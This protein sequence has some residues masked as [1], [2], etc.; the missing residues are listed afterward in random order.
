MAPISWYSPTTSQLRPYRR[1]PKVELHRHLEGSLRLDTLLDIAR[2]HGI[3]LP[4]G[5]DLRSLVQMQVGDSLTFSTFLSKFQ[6]L[7][8]FYRS[9]EVIARVTREAVVD[10][11][12]DGIL[13]MELRFTP[14][15]LTRIQD[16]GLGEVMDWVIESAR[17]ASR[18]YGISVGLIVSVNRNESVELAEQVAQLAV[19]RLGR[20][21]VGFDLAGNEAGFSAAPFAGILREVK[22]SGLKL[23]VHAGE[24]GGA[25]NVREAIEVFG[26][27]R[28]AHG[29]RVMEDQNVVALARERQT[30]FEVCITSNYQSGVVPSL[31]A[32]PL[33]KMI[34]AGL[35]VT[36]NTDDPS[37]S[38]I[39]L[40][41]EYRI[42]VESLQLSRANLAERIIAAAQVAFLP[43][44]EKQA[45]ISR[46]RDRLPQEPD[47]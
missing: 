34:E 7:R 35:Y 44:R 41:D 27:D 21:I 39:T 5:P 43:A 40:S 13:H 14:V 33:V 17:D 6:M 16:F 15:A 10:A 42:A 23:S 38:Q 12:E 29:V 36:L 1:F 25:D 8:L 20:G 47:K 45:L 28:V 4:L 3:T 37:I 2:N 31:T 11:A 22:A 30:P 26:T 32:H 9:A 18:E 19:D 46:I 24:W